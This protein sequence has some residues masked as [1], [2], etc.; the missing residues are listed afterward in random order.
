MKVHLKILLLVFICG[1]TSDYAQKPPIV[2]KEGVYAPANIKIDGQATEWNNKYKAYDT[3]NNIFYTIC[4]DDK[5]LYLIIHTSEKNTINKIFIGS[6]TFKINSVDHPGDIPVAI[7]YPIKTGNNGNYILAKTAYDKFIKDSIG[8]AKDISELIQLKNKQFGNT[9]KELYANGI[10]EFDATTLSI[11]NEHG[12][13]V[14]ALFDDHLAYTYELALPLKYLETTLSKSNKLRYTIRLNGVEHDG[15]I[16]PT[17]LPMVRPDGSEVTDMN[18][19]YTETPTDFG[20]EY[21]LAK[22]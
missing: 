16:Q 13:K 1:W 3:R 12:I 19:L 22:K 9:Y 15:H 10:K 20:G 8:N 21:T 11:Y 14:K 17:M 6:I 18:K 2:Q 7:T 5:N 4:N